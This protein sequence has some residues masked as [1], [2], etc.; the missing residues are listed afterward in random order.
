[1]IHLI[2]IRQD[3]TLDIRSKF[4][5]VPIKIERNLKKLLRNYEEA[6]I[7]STCNRTEI[8][9]S[10][11]GCDSDIVNNIFRLLKWDVKYREY[12]FHMKGEEAAVH[13]LELCCGFHSKILG[14]DQIL[15][16]VKAAQEASQKVKGLKNGLQRLFQI[17]VTCGKEFRTEAEIRKIPVSSSSIVVQECIKRAVKRFMLIGY[18]EVGSLVAKYIFENDFEILYICVREPEKLKSDVQLKGR[19]NVKLIS[20]EERRGLYSD[21]QCI[22]SCTSA[23][24]TIVHRADLAG[25]NLLIYDLSVPRDV[26]E[27]AAE[28][29]NVLLKNIDAISSIDEE[30]KLKR[31]KRMEECYYIIEKH[32][33]I[34]REWLSIREI[35]PHI[36]KFME[37]GE[38]IYKERYKVFKNKRHTKDNAYLAEVLI[39]SASNAYINRAIEVLKEEKLKGR[40]DECLRILEKIFY[41]RD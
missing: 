37:K 1:M 35:T 39:K 26:D 40:E 3:F 16:Q 27:D 32:M 31:R 15:G 11:A 19:S 2:G 28:L 8:Y 21:V 10:T 14:E 6:V 24:H 30:N 22:I 20:F 5:I 13:L 41:P 36:R 17:A 25:N 38:K 29:P 34:Y 33:K 4:A 18:G 12:T 23:P 7:I 9:V